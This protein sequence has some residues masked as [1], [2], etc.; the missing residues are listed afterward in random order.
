M[1]P[2]MTVNQV[3]EYLGVGAEIVR[4]WLRKGVLPGRKLGTKPKAEWRVL[5][6]SVEEF[7][8]GKGGK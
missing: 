6:S 7:V 3:A 8:A 1:Q 5:E 4:V 2:I